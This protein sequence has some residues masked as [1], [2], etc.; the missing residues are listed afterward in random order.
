MYDDSQELSVV[1]SGDL[2]VVGRAKGGGFDSQ[3]NFYLYEIWY[4]L[5]T[6]LLYLFIEKRVGLEGL[7][8][9]T[10]RLS[11]VYSIPLSY[12][13]CKRMYAHLYKSSLSPYT[14]IQK[15]NTCRSTQIEEITV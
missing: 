7:E 2:S 10:L 8:P 13:P 4:T 15:A 5:Q 1:Y 3:E 11:G 6:G 12:K 9:S 14:L